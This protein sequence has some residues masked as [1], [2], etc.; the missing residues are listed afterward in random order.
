MAKKSFF[1]MALAVL[2]VSAQVQAEVYFSDDFNHVCTDAWARINYQGWY[3]QE[4]LGMGTPGTEWV[5]GDWD[6]YR[7][8]PTDPCDPTTTPTQVCMNAVV[9]TS[10]IG[11]YGDAND[12]AQPW[13]PDY[14]GPEAD[15]VLRMVSCNGNWEHTGNTGPFLYKLVEGDFTATVEIAAYDCWWYNLGGIMAR[16]PNPNDVDENHTQVCAFPIYNIGNRVNDTVDGATSWDGDFYTNS[17]YS[18]LH[19]RLQRVGNTFYYYTSPDGETWTSLNVDADTGEDIGIVRDDFPAEV[20]VGLFHC[21]FNSDWL[22][23]MDFDDFVIEVPDE[24]EE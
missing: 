24:T 16:V 17:S 2:L 15:G 22:V 11:L 14:D 4:V 1:L 21:N 9:A 10:G 18:D 20:Q 13:Y 5:I 7:S 12:T 19:L 6:G 8:Y 23:G 3:E